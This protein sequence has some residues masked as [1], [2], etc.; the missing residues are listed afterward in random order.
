MLPEF[1]GGDW[2]PFFDPPNYVKSLVLPSSKESRKSSEQ[3]DTDSE[4]DDEPASPPKNQRRKP[5]KKIN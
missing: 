5:K 3:G 1:L 2:N 4:T